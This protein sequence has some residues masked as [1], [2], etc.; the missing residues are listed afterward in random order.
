MSNVKKVFVELNALLLANQD[1]LVSSIMPQI[2][3][4]MSAKNSSNGPA[5]YKDEHGKV[6]AVFCYYHK[7]WELVSEHT[8]GAKVGTN[9]G[10]NSMCKLGVNAWTKQQREAKKAEAELLGK[11]SSGE[12]KV[13]DLASAREE[14]E[15]SKSLVSYPT[16]YPIAF[17]SLD[18]LEDYLESGVKPATKVEA[19]P[20]ADVH[21][22][23]VENNGFDDVIN[24]DL[25]K[26]TGAKVKKPRA[27]K[28]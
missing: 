20:S 23:E 6:I 7:K 12:L 21:E 27:K 19:E 24:S 9:T 8:Y 15:A 14:I 2:L 5:S 10:L 28:V 11:L 1:K 26:A 16:N 3:E 17:D 13:E 25:A 4:L 22:I 18:E